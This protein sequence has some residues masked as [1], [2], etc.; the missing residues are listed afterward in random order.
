MYSDP[1][2][3]IMRD[4][5]MVIEHL[6]KYIKEYEEILEEKQS[7]INTIDKQISELQQLRNKIN[8][9]GSII[10]CKMEGLKEYKQSYMD[11]F[12]P[13]TIE[14]TKAMMHAPE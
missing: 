4:A 13:E 7:E 8:N 10:H 14:V 2:G 12:Q 6:G 1:G 3:L 5:Y 9:E 11:K